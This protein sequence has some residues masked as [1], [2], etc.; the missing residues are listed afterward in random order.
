MKFTL[1]GWD[2]TIDGLDLY[3]KTGQPP[4]IFLRIK[5]TYVGWFI[6]G[7][8][9]R[10]WRPTLNRATVKL[11]KLSTEIAEKG[12]DFTPESYAFIANVGARE[13]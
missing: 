4:V 13:T 12:Y 9:R 6:T 3:S 7:G 8:A 2:P 11:L 10:Y 5:Q 1:E